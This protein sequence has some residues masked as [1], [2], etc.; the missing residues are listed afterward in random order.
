MKKILTFLIKE[1][2]LFIIGGLIYVSIE[3]MS[4]GFSH[5][6]MAICGGLCF[7]V[8][9]LMNEWYNWE[10][11]LI[12]QSLSGAITITCL[13]FIFGYIFNIKLNMNIWDYSDLRFNL[14]GQICLHHSILYWIPLSAISVI[15]DDWLRY[16]LF[17]E[18]IYRYK[19]I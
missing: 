12:S 3:L 13:E 10:M 7:V 4:R 11:S 5:W 17:K 18:K 1:L 6:S 14:Y 19:I 2:I 8:I 9:G 16:K 15:L